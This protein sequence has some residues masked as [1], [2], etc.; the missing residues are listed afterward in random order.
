MGI[1]R[2]GV[3]RTLEDEA[4]RLIRESLAGVTSQSAKSDILTP[5]KEQDRLSREVYNGTGF[6][7]PAIRQGMFHRA[8]NSAYPHLNSRDGIARAILP[9]FSKAMT[10]SSLQSFMD[11]QHRLAEPETPE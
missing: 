4:N 9:A 5:W 7:D 10:D 11:E 1:I 3:H 2:Y 8:Y 6:P